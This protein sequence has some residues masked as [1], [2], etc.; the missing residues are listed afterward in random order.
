MVN[1]NQ[2]SQDLLTTSSN[3]LNDVDTVYGQILN[4]N[5]TSV[6]SANNILNNLA[7]S[8]AALEAKTATAVEKSVNATRDTKST[9]DRITEVLQK[10]DNIGNIDNNKILE[11]RLLVQQARFNFDTKDLGA[12]V[13]FFRDA[14]EDNRKT[15]Q[16][17]QLKLQNL[18]DTVAS[19]STVAAQLRVGKK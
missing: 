10:F 16:E 3:V 18:R 13:S 15:I 2:Q 7:G 5:A 6:T 8:V 19:L 11:L 4:Q 9:K 1:I 14:V 17:K 12:T